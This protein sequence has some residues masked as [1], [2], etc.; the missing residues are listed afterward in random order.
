MIVAPLERHKPVY[1]IFNQHERGSRERLKGRSEWYPLKIAMHLR[2]AERQQCV[3]L[4]W[5]SQS[6]CE[7]ITARLEQCGNSLTDACDIAGQYLGHWRGEDI[8]LFFCR[9]R[10]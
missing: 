6:W 5:S 2:Q 8:Q 4:D 1:R 7:S 10:C 3:A 9:Y